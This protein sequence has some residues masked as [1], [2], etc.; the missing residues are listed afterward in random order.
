[1][2]KSSPSPQPEQQEQ[3][4]HEPD[5]VSEASLLLRFKLLGTNASYSSASSSSSS[6]SSSVTN[7]NDDLAG[8]SFINNA[9]R[10]P[11]LSDCLTLDENDR[12]PPSEGISSLAGGIVALGKFD[13]L[14]IGHLELAIQASKIGVPFLLS[15]IGM[16][17]IFGWEPSC[18][19][20][21]L[22]GMLFLLQ[23]VEKLSAEL[24]ISGVV[25]GENYRFGYRASG[26]SSDLVRLCK[27]YAMK[28]SIV[29]S[30]MDKKNRQES[31]DDIDS[32]NSNEQGQVSSTRVRRA[33]SN[34]DMGYVSEL[35]G[36]N[37]RLICN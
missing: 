13:A 1:M 5:A 14:H 19:G 25:A 3:T 23:F 20:E 10:P 16:A 31:K 9:S 33:L 6:S 28:A 18:V 7:N 22:F 4:N 30:V 27:E 17:E 8:V 37:H 35:L 34:G 15:F 36:R 26:D 32:K 12:D 24:K 21:T 2:F 29:D 11:L